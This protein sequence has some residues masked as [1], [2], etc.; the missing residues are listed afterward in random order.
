MVMGKHGLG[1]MNENGELHK[2]FLHHESKCVTEEIVFPPK[3]IDKS[4]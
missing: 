4:M 1:P 2:N 3:I